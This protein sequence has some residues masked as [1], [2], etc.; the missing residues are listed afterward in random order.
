[1]IPMSVVFHKRTDPPLWPGSPEPLIHAGTLQHVAVLDGGMES[2][3]PSIMV[4]IDLPGGQG[5]VIAEQTARQIATLG[6]M[7]M[8]KYPHLFDD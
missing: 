3:L 2:G 7:L 1:M 5:Q 4:R 8:A 6:R